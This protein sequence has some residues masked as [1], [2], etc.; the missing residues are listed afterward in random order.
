MNEPTSEIVDLATAERQ[1]RTV[2][3]RATAIRR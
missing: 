3:A 1:A 2:A